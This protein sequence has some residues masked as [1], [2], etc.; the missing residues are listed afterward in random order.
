MWLQ[1]FTHTFHDFGGG[2]DDP[3]L[4]AALTRST[5]TLSSYDF[6]YIIHGN[7]CF[8]QAVGDTSFF[9]YGMQECSVHSLIRLLYPWVQCIYMLEC[10]EHPLMQPLY[11]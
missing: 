2:A 8:F 3:H 6:L 1:I 11:L 10:S 9:C 4:S 7:G 5:A